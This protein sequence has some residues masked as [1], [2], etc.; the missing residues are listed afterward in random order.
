MPV[1]S[2]TPLHQ[3]SPELS[4]V[5]TTR[6]DCALTVAMAAAA[7]RRRYIMRAAQAAGFGAREEAALGIDFHVLKIFFENDDPISL[8]LLFVTATVP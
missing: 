6:A 8:R 1:P 3:V 2:L 4:T 5:V 7:A